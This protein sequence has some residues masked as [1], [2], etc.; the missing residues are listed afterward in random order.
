MRNARLYA[1]PEVIA[2]AMLTV[3]SVPA[4]LT[5]QADVP[6]YQTDFPPEEFK[7]RW[8]KVYDQIGPTAVAIVQGVGLTPGFIFP[9]QHNEF[10]YLSGVE[11]PGSYIMLDGRTRTATLYLPRRNARLEAAEGRVLSA[12]D[13]DLV[14]RLVGVDDVQPVDAMRE[15]WPPPAARAG[16]AAP[17]AGGGDGGRGATP[18]LVIYTPFAPAEN[19]AMSRGEAASA[20]RAQVADYWDQR[21]S[22]ELNF[23]HLLQTRLGAEVRDLSPIL[24][25][26]RS[27]KS[28]REI[29]LI[30]RSSQIAALG[31]IE[32]MKATEPGVYEYQLDA[33]ARYVFLVNGA[34]L[35]AYRSI[36]AAGM[37]NIISLHYFRNTSQ[38][39]AGDLVLM[40]Y[41]P[42]FRYYTSDI[43]RM[44]PVSGTFNPEQRA[45]LGFILEYR[46]AIIAR[47]RPGVTSQQVMEE[48]RAAME[49]VF[50]RT[51]FVKPEHERAARDL[52]QS[53]GGVFSHSVGMAVHDV[54]G[55]SNP[56]KVGQVFSVDPQLRMRDANGNT[57]LYMRYEDVGVVTETGFENFTAFMPSTLEEIEKTVQMKGVVQAYP[58]NAMPW[59]KN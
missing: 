30:R 8:A 18:R 45:L 57:I 10:Y 59:K 22:E 16:G 12:D 55:R 25:G 34:R 4:G 1:R 44:W 13:A 33:A 9:R 43:G 47:I 51:K 42:D 35:D 37:T 36:T 50:A 11:T 6:V 26:L 53:G 3:I 41:A 39:R 17:A 46:N 28:P 2:L 14:K 29:D 40:D 23:V 5:G 49:P 31:I 54:G 7:A 20:A 19:Y 56:L 15:G 52:V 24:D 58:A 48:A 32:A 21:P 38:A 27:I